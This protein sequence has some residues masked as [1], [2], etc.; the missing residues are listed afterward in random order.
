MA[1]I[2]FADGT[3][4]PFPKESP[5]TSADT[6]REPPRYIVLHSTEGGFAGAVSWLLNRISRASAHFVVSR[7]GEMRQLVSVHRRAWHAGRS[8]WDRR[9]NLNTCSIGIEMEHWDKKQDWPLAQLKAVAKLVAELRREFN[10]P[11]GKVVGHD[12]IAWPRGRKID[13]WA[14]PWTSFRILIK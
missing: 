7:S 8:K 9:V 10:I 1:Q 3:Y 5:N 13:P 4:V 2:Y 12:Q 11:V 6:D 14:F